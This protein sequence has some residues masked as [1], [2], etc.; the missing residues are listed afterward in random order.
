MGAGLAAAWAYF[1][2]ELKSK[3]DVIC[4]SSREELENHA[5]WRVAA[6]FDVDGDF[7]DLVSQERDIEES[8]WNFRFTSESDEYEVSLVVDRN[9]GWIGT[10]RIRRSRRA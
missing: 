1:R 9:D 2:S 5:R 10:G 8:K 6:A 3:L 7:L 4:T